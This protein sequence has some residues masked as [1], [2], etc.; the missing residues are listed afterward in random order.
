L[1]DRRQ[2]PHSRG[3]DRARITRARQAAEA[4]FAPKRPVTEQS[5]LNSPPAAEPRKARIL[6]TS[7]PAPAPIEVEKTEP[8]IPLEERARPEIPV[9]KFA[10]IRALVKYGMTVS[11]VAEVYGVAVVV[12]ERVLRQT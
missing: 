9:S 1:L 4:L 2:R 6:A 10:H 3:D 12:I 5:V 8:P 7:P 11:Q